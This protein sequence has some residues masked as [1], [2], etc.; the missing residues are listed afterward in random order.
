MSVLE[1]YPWLILPLLLIAYVSYRAFMY[2]TR[3]GR[4][5]IRGT[6]TGPQELAIETDFG[7]FRVS[8]A[9]QRVVWKRR[10]NE[11]QSY[12][13]AEIDGI[14]LAAYSERACL[15]EIIQ[16]LDV[17]DLDPKFM[18]TRDYTVVSIRFKD[19]SQLPLYVVGELTHREA[20]MPE[21]L[22]ELEKTILGVL[23]LYE[24]ARYRSQA[25]YRVLWDVFYAAEPTTGRKSA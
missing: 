19:G 13:L 9:A 2:R 3:G 20:T 23:R 14:E 18:D 4:L 7:E 10:Q 17:W 24:P 12:P 15:A 22:C 6:G 5:R 11:H 16:G 1:L 8:S 21:W 25:A